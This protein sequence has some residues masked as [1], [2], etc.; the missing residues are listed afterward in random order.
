MY[1]VFVVCGQ[2]NLKYYRRILMKFSR[3]V[4]IGR[5]RKWLDFWLKLSHEGSH[6]SAN[7]FVNYLTLVDDA[8]EPPNL[9]A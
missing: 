3:Q 4:R 1:Y 2:H 7:F 5:R 9:A 6:K 8:T